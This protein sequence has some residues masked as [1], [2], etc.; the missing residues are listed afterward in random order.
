MGQNITY[1]L[2]SRNQDAPEHI[3]AS[4]ANDPK[5]VFDR[6]IKRFELQP[7]DCHSFYRVGSSLSHFSSATRPVDIAA[8][9]FAHGKELIHQMRGL[10]EIREEAHRFLAWH[11]PVREAIF[12]I[13]SNDGE[14]TEDGFE[15][16]EELMAAGLVEEAQDVSRPETPRYR[17][18]QSGSEYPILRYRA[19]V[20]LVPSYTRV[21]NVEPEPADGPEL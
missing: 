11:L 10:P 8:Y 4:S 17:L 1:V 14:I 12:P 7:S 15:I 16:L 18:T 2:R 19:A 3:H 21:R 13:M 9:E 6:A 5:E 20:Y